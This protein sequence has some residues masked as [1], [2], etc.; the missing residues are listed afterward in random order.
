MTAPRSRGSAPV[1]G[2]QAVLPALA[3]RG[4]GFLVLWIVLAGTA[5]GDFAVG[6]LAAALAAW[7]SVT[8][9]PPGRGRFS[10]RGSARLAAHFLVQSVVAG[11]DVARRAFHPRLPIKPG[12]VQYPVGFAPGPER[13]AFKAFT[14]LLPGT[15]TV[16][17]EEA[18]ILYHCLDVDQPV[19]RELAVEEA[20]LRGALPPPPDV[21]EDVPR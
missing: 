19:L 7:A 20:R 15:V 1:P 4:A 10:A 12:F 18:G 17:E 11:W 9:L 5:P 6:L 14:S 2:R 13:A 3:L 8:L 16:G 21:P